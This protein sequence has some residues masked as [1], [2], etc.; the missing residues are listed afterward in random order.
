MLCWDHLLLLLLSVL[1][2]LLCLRVCLLHLAMCPF[3]H[4][5][6]VASICALKTL[7]LVLLPDPLG[8]DFMNSDCALACD[9]HTVRL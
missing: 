7:L 8:I 3:V 1:P 2:L 6:V 5:Y 9:L 4:G